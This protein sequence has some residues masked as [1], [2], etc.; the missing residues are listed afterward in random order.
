MSKK[1]TRFIFLFVAL[2]LLLIINQFLIINN[3]YL[4]VSWLDQLMHFLGGLFTGF[5]GI[6]FLSLCFNAKQKM[7]IF[8]IFIASLLTTLVIG[9]LWEIVELNSET[10]LRLKLAEIITNED[11]QNDVLFNLLGALAGWLYFILLKSRAGLK[12][13]PL[14]DKR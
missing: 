7:P 10:I 6:Y 13:S 1:Q 11:S 9:C 5:L 8:F 2:L 12:T 3:I 4:E 14:L